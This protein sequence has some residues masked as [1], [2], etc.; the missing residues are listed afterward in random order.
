M[1]VVINGINTMAT[2]PY[3]DGKGNSLQLDTT[4]REIGIPRT[5]PRIP[6]TSGFGFFVSFN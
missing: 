5:N 2:T 1:M 6:Y 4:R 3:S